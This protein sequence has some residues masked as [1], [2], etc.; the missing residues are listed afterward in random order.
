MNNQYL[1][2]HGGI[3]HNLKELED[4]NRID[5]FKEIP[6]TDLF[7][8]LLWADPVN[9]K[10]GDCNNGLVLE[11]QIRGCSFY[12]GSALTKSFLNKYNLKKIIR[13]H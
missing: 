13:A 4:I 2:V 5:R 7:C 8:D 6:K 12:F 9:N 1:C 3:S 11:N 10:T